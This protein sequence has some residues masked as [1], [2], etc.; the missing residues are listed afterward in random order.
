L[1]LLDLTAEQRLATSLPFFGAV[2]T[3]STGHGP[4]FPSPFAISAAP[5]LVTSLS[6]AGV[7]LAPGGDAGSQLKL[8]AITNQ[9]QVFARREL[10]K[11]SSKSLANPF[12]SPLVGKSFSQKKGARLDEAPPEYP[13]IAQ[14]ADHA[15]VKPWNGKEGGDEDNEEDETDDV[16]NQRALQEVDLSRESFLAVV[17]D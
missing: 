11:S 3:Y 14:K 4:A 12:K 5:K 10:V 16:A 6:D 17:R 2:M 8:P 13:R 9:S 1:L 7:A 15:K